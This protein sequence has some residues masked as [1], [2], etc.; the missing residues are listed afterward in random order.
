MNDMYAPTMNTVSADSSTVMA[1]VLSC[2][3]ERHRLVRVRSQP[4]QSR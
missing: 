2:S 3:E 1:T 4:R